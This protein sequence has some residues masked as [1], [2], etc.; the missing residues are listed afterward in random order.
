[1]CPLQTPARLVAKHPSQLIHPLAK[2]PAY[3]TF[4]SF[5]FSS[6]SDGSY[7]NTFA[8]PHQALIHTRP[9]PPIIFSF[10]RIAQC[11]AKQRSNSRKISNQTK[12]ILQETMPEK[13]AERQKNVLAPKALRLPNSNNK[14][15]TGRP[16]PSVPRHDVLFPIRHIISGPS[17]T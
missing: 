2:P 6:S 12:L 3:H 17:G 1:M 16:N 8:L 9:P 7:C 13:R 14:T 5:S 10:K 15:G 4:F 11:T